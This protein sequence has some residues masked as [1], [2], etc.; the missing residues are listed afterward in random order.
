MWDVTREEEEGRGV[1][2]HGGPWME[3]PL[4]YAL[5]MGLWDNV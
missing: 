5:C 4:V 1:C 2:M 3:V